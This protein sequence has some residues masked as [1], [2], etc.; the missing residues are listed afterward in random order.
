[1]RAREYADADLELVLRKTTPAALVKQHVP[2][3]EFD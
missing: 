1:M 2:Q 3:Y